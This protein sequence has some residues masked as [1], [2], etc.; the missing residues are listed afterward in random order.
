M[1]LGLVPASGFVLDCTSVWIAELIKPCIYC[2]Q[3]GIICVPSCGQQSRLK[4]HKS[5]SRS[6]NAS[7]ADYFLLCVK[8]EKVEPGEKKKISWPDSY[9]IV[10][11][12]CVETL[13]KRNRTKISCNRP[14]L[15]CLAV[16]KKWRNRRSYFSCIWA[17]FECLA[18]VDG[19]WKLFCQTPKR[20]SGFYDTM[21]HNY[22]SLDAYNAGNTDHLS[23][24]SKGRQ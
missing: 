21:S 5:S 22:A 13:I 17:Y 12:K 15:I 16:S 6:A 3:M 9:K 14:C 2:W 7:E 18:F 10:Q 11:S 23:W 4:P 1:T 20:C 8:S 24:W 19:Q